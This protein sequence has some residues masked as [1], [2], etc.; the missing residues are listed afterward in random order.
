MTGAT[1]RK[2]CC[3]KA[4]KPPQEA[5]IAVIF[6]GLPE[7]YESEGFDRADMKMPDGQLRMIDAVAAANPNTVVVLLCGSAVECPWGPTE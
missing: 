3:C 7:R 1:P 4:E 2:I 6:A 5:E